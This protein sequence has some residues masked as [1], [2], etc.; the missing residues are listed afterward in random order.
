MRCTHASQYWPLENLTPRG[1]HRKV[2][3]QECAQIIK[4]DPP[5]NVVKGH[6]ETRSTLL[7]GVRNN[8]HDRL[9][10]CLPG[11]HDS[12]P[13][14][15]GHNID[16]QLPLYDSWS[17][18]VWA[19]IR[20]RN[21]YFHAPVRFWGRLVLHNAEV[22]T[23]TLRPTHHVR[24]SITLH[25]WLNMTPIVIGCL[26]NFP[27][28]ANRYSYFTI[29]EI[30]HTQFCTLPDSKQHGPRFAPYHLIIHARFFTLRSTLWLVFGCLA[31]TARKIIKWTSF[32]IKK[33]K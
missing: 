33:K 5:V 26:H 15:H 9:N 13:Q 16:G 30:I 21:N 1:Q 14:F 18:L 7:S 24:R 31:R 25:F 29:F 23:S 11:V 12:W 8:V 20:W 22:W 10:Q 28:N 17:Q 3:D 32:F 19:T 6:R 27:R 2:P 4:W